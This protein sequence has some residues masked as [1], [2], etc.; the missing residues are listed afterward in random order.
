MF[1]RSA[2]NPACISAATPRATARAVGSA[3]HSW[4][5]GNR[6]ATYSPIAKLSHTTM[7][8]WWRHGTRPDGEWR[9]IFSGVSGWRSGIRIS[10]NATPAWRRTSQAR[11]DHDE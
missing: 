9:R 1:W 5:W 10:S 8:P 7:S 4:A 11:S 3:G 2:A 6:S